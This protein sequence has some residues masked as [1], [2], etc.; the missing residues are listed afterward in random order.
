M[1]LSNFAAQMNGYGIYMPLLLVLTF[2]LTGFGIYL[3]L[4]AFRAIDDLD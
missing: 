1:V 2:R 4:G 3:E